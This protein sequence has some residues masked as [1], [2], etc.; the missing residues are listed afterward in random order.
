[1]TAGGNSTTNRLKVYGP[2]WGGTA[3]I[4]ASATS[5]MSNV[6]LINIVQAGAATWTGTSKTNTFTG[7]TSQ[8]IEV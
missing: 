2:P 6:D 4:T 8:A 3:T 5:G 7:Y 1:M